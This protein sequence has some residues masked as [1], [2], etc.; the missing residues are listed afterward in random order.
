MQRWEV[1]WEELELERLIGGGSFGRVYLARWKETEVAV[2]VRRAAGS[3]TALLDA[4]LL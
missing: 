3:S 2:K 4:L 1:Q